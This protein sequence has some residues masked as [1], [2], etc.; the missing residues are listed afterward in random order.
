MLLSALKYLKNPINFIFFFPLSCPVLWQQNCNLNTVYAKQ[1]CFAKGSLM[2]VK[3]PLM[4]N[5]LLIYLILLQYLT[6]NSAEPDQGTGKE[7]EQRRRNRTKIERD[8]Q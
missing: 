8:K 3:L 6:C 2:N 5:K 1:I 7:E 4:P